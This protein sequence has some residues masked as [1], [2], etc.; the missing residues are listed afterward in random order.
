MMRIQVAVSNRHAHLT[1]RDAEMLGLHPKPERWLQI[2][3]NYASDTYVEIGGLRFR[4]LLPFRRYSQIEILASD[5]RRLNTQPCYRNSGNLEG[6][7]T[8]EVGSL[9]LPAIVAIPHVHVP[10]AWLQRETAVDLHGAKE[11]TLNRVMMWPTEG[12]DAP[13]LHIDKDEALAYGV[14]GATRAS[15]ELRLPFQWPGIAA[16][17]LWVGTARAVANA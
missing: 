2:G 15:M 5:C 17:N 11:I 1:A 6:A 12:C 14:D 10:Q 9:Q 16:L 4:I 3:E 13:I 7:P 8:L